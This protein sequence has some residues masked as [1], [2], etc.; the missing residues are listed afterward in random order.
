[1]DFENKYSVPAFIGGFLVALIIYLLF[2]REREHRIEKKSEYG[3]IGK[4]LIEDVRYSVIDYKAEEEEV[5]FDMLPLVA[6][7]NELEGSMIMG[8]LEGAGLDVYLITSKKE[9]PDE[10]QIFDDEAVFGWIVISQ[11]DLI[12]GVELLVDYEEKTSVELLINERMID[13]ADRIIRSRQM[14]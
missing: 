2:N 13:I 10:Y 14:G 7:R 8:I 11:D 12:D 3:G 1:M 4:K 9:I 6:V 5:K